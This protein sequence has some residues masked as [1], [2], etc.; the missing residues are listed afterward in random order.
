MDKVKCK[1]KKKTWPNIK[2]DKLYKIDNQN[3]HYNKTYHF[4]C[5]QTK[6]SP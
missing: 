6:H 2:S 3:K 4:T 5:K 1:K